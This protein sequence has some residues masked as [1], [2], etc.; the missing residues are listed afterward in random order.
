LVDFITESYTGVGIRIIASTVEKNVTAPKDQ[1]LIVN[2]ADISI[3]VKGIT[4]Q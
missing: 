3:T 2:D 4:Q 1:V